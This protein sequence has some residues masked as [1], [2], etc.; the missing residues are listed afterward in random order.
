MDDSKNIMKM[1]KI[2]KYLDIFLFIADNQPTSVIQ[3]QDY[4]EENGRGIPYQTLN[5]TLKSWTKEGFIERKSI[6]NQELQMGGPRFRYS[7]RPK[8]KKFVDMFTRTKE[9]VKKVEMKDG[10]DTEGIIRS[11]TEDLV[12]IVYNQETILKIQEIVMRELDGY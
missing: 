8:G 11:I 10:I 2:K 4:L 9:I 5:S 3:I 6:P 1:A 12:D 7:L